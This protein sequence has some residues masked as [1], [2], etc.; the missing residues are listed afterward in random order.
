MRLRCDILGHGPGLSETIV[1]IKTTDG[2]VEVV[3]DDSFVHDGALLIRRVVERRKD[4]ALVELPQ[5]STTGR[6]R[7]WVNESALAAG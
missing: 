2:R 4:K 1:E 7:V 3:V 6:W 5:E